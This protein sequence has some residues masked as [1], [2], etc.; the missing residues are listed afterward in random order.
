MYTDYRWAR[1]ARAA[2]AEALEREAPRAI[3]YSTIT[4]S[5]LW[6]RP[7]AIRFDAL[8]VD[9]RPGR[10]GVWQRAVERRRLAAAPLVVPSSAD[11]RFPTGVVVPP[12][13]DRS[14][15]VDGARDVAAV[16]YATNPEK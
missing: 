1:A 11:V 16:T 3:L 13:V 12:A 6:P 5:L 7:G 10:H 4:A 8:S 14:G 2:A 15:P 9:N